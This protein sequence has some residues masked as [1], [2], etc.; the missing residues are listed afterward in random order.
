MSLRVTILG[1]GS[2]TGVPRVGGDWGNCDPDNP[3]NRRQRCS[4][5]VQRFGANGAS[6]AVLVDTSPDLRNQLLS[7]GVSQIDAV[8]FTHDH[9]DH[10]HG[11]DDLRV[12]A[13]NR[14][15]RVP[16][17]FDQ[18]TADIVQSRFSYCFATPPGSDYPPILDANII[19]PGAD[20]VIEG[21]GG[22]ITAT[23]FE[24]VHGT[25]SALGFRFGNVAYLPD[26]SDIPERAET[27][28]QGLD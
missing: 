14:R 26:V 13:L 19:T 3:K 5:L 22:P 17:Y 2:S 27:T 11:I 15:A 1:C 4:I 9:A 25:I 6:T 24:V 28:L 18:R 23:A 16:V 8:L 21:A 10:T 7:T 12:L 20:I